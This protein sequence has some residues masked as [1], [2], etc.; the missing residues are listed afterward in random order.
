MLL[1]YYGVVAGRWAPN[2]AYFFMASYSN[3][4]G[5][6]YELLLSDLVSSMD[7]VEGG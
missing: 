1:Y 2:L 4:T 3:G 7:P 5:H 6:H